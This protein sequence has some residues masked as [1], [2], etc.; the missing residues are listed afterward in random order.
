MALTGA[1]AVTGESGCDRRKACRRPAPGGPTRHL[2]F[3]LFG[4]WLWCWLY[5]SLCFLFSVSALCLVLMLAFGFDFSFG[6]SF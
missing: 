1:A 2:W 5:N 3:C 6:F 4:V